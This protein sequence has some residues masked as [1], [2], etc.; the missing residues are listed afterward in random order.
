MGL[1]ANRITGS[2]I[3]SRRPSKYSLYGSATVCGAR[4]SMH[5]YA[6][7]LR[8]RCL[9]T[10]GSTN[11]VHDTVFRSQCT[12]LKSQLTHAIYITILQLQITFKS[13]AFALLYHLLTFKQSYKQD[14]PKD[15]N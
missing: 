4:V 1:D 15:I 14:Y 10:G 8:V 3:Y 13:I 6:C 11:V 5:A 2:K 9:S 7:Y 12:G